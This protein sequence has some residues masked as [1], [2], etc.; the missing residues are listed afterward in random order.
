MRLK[1]IELARKNNAGHTQLPSQKDLSLGKTL[2]KDIIK[3]ESF[4]R[5]LARRI[6]PALL[7]LRQ[8]NVRAGLGFD[9]PFHADLVVLGESFTQDA[10]RAK[11]LELS[12][13]IKKA[14]LLVCGCSC[15]YDDDVQFWLRQGVAK[16]DGIDLY[17]QKHA[18]EQA[19]VILKNRYKSEIEFQH[20]FI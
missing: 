14:R 3:K 8:K 12:P 17:L 19:S 11:L 9:L 20:A 5:L 6:G 15:G 7:Q 13:D 16:L 4:K 1:E 10:A 18:W 2:S